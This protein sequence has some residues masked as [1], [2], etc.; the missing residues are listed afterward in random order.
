M[1]KSAIY[2]RGLAMGAADIVPGVSGGTM[3][4]ITGIYEQLIRTLSGIG[5]H[6]LGVW[7]REGFVAA[8]QRGNFTFLAV[9]LAGMLTSVVVLAS[10]IVS[11]MESYPVQLWAFFSGLIVASVVV[12]WRPLAHDPV[13][14]VALVAGTLLALMISLFPTVNGADV[15][16]WMF[17]FGGAIAICAMI[18]PGISGSFIL[19]LLGLYQPVLQAIDMRHIPSL[20][21]FAAGCVVGLMSMVRLLR[22]LLER[23]HDT[24]MAL[25]VGFMAGSL[26]KLWPWR[27]IDD[28][29]GQQQW[30]LPA[31]YAL[32]TGQPSQLGWACLTAFIAIVM[33][34]ALSRHQP[35]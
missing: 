22:W 1:R 35:R 21:V 30:F 14:V 25:M 2:A 31:D 10:F 19:L 7:Q 17:F 24:L 11:L 6:L 15:Q 8:W 27:V 34:L 20:L 23:Y 3:A 28:E 18:L 32:A 33:V 12:V 26:I 9:L 5:P 16:P 13:R 4:L 29:Y